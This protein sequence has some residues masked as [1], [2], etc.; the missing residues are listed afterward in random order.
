MLSKICYECANPITSLYEG[1]REKQIAEGANPENTVVIPNGIDIAKFKQ[2]RKNRPET[3]PFVLCLIGRIVP[4]KDI[5][6]FIRAINI[7]KKEIPS[8]EGWIAGPI[9]ENPDYF[10]EC[11]NLASVLDLEKNVKFMPGMQNILDIF[12]KTGLTILSSISEGMPLI[13]LESFASG[14]PAL[15]TNVGACPELILG[16][17]KGDKEIGDSGGIVNIADPQE[18]AKKA[19]ALLTDNE[20][21]KKA[22]LAAIK[23]VEEYYN[24]EQ[25]F[26]KYR[27]IYDI[28]LANEF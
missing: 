19:I 21:W 14:V 24:Q 26:I 7:V 11:K 10:E 22:Q 3:T 12:S 17:N 4:I 16:G 20:K 9:D 8:I 1:A 15:T 25:M 23:R 2:C 28:L 18:L 13:I 5:K 27:K 6:T